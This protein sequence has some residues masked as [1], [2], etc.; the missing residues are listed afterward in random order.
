M[1][2]TTTDSGCGSPVSLR[3][4]L[5]HTIAE[6]AR[7][8]GHPDLLRERVDGAT[9]YGSRIRRGPGTRPP[10]GDRRPVA[11]PRR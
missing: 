11:R 4:I 2:A 3:G 8:N 6:Y 9:G 10:V 1:S 5:V 7:H